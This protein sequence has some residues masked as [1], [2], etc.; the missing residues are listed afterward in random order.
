V[1]IVTVHGPYTFGS[2][3]V[4]AAGPVMATVQANNGLIWTF[5]IDGPTTRVAADFD[6]TFTGGTPASTADNPGP[7]T[8]TYSTAG[9]KTATLV[10][11][12]A[13]TGNNPYPPAGSYPITVTAVSGAAPLI[14]EGEQGG[15][16]VDVSEYMEGEHPNGAVTEPRPE[17]TTSGDGEVPIAFD[18]AA[19]TVAEVQEYAEEHPDQAQEMLDAE[20]AGKNRT[21]LINYLSTLIPFDPGAHTVTEVIAFVEDNPDLLEDVLDAERE[22]KNRTTLVSHLESMQAA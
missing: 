5:K 20:V 17:S 22:G 21:T 6:W 14:L 16:N 15:E 2:K 19:H 4:A 3:A 9:A 11:S 18:P 12:G 10:V 7:I 8:V 1:S 13:G